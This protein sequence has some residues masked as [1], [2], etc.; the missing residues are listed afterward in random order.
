MRRWRDGG[1]G[2]EG[3]M[4]KVEVRD[5]KSG[6]RDGECGGDRWVRWRGQM[7]KVEGTDG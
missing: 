7:G 2:G 5:E 1:G 4:G 3:D 6:G